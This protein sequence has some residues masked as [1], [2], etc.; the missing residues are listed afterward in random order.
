TRGYP[1]RVRV[2]DRLR[3]TVSARR[4]GTGTPRKVLSVAVPAR[5]RVDQQEVVPSHR[6]R[7]SRSTGIIGRG[8]PHR[9]PGQWIAGRRAGGCRTRGLATRR[10][11]G[12]RTRS[13]VP[14]RREDPGRAF[15]GAGVDHGNDTLRSVP[16]V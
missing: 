1:R 14:G 13:T 3:A 10:R 12:H 11:P 8:W 16:P 6:G 2:S 4:G 9:G 5:A 15:N 7:L